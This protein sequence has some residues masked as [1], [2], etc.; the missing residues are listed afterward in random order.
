MWGFL[1]CKCTCFVLRGMCLNMSYT[2]SGSVQFSRWPMELRGWSLHCLHMQG[3]K[4]VFTPRISAPATP[5]PV[6][7]M[8]CQFTHRLNTCKSLALVVKVVARYSQEPSVTSSSP[9]CALWLRS[10]CFSA[11]FD[12]WGTV[13]PSLC[14]F[15]SHGEDG[16]IP[17]LSSCP[18][19]RV[20]AYH[21]HSF[22]SA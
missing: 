3:R 19:H 9:W 10:L 13:F 14:V 8:C 20:L 4:G 1:N 21:L 17:I 7:C 22:L 2:S 18:W 11:P 16:I 12:R 6:L 5:H 15:R